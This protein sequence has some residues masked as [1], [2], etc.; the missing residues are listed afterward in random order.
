MDTIGRVGLTE[1]HPLI[2]TE[3]NGSKFN[4]DESHYLRPMLYELQ[5]KSTIKSQ[6]SMYMYIYNAFHSS[7]L[8]NKEKSI[9]IDTTCYK[10]FKPKP[11]SSKHC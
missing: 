7:H 2:N 4:K 1:M 8:S 6:F 9:F 11:H 3:K 10:V 5:Y